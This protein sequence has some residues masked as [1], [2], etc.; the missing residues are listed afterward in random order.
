MTKQVKKKMQDFLPRGK[1]P[2]VDAGWR[3][4]KYEKWYSRFHGDLIIGRMRARGRGGSSAAFLAFLFAL[5]RLLHDNRSL[6]RKIYG[7]P[8]LGSGFGKP[9]MAGAMRRSYFGPQVP[10]MKD[11]EYAL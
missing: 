2:G 1:F 5:T 6:L 3:L 4:V 11:L 8:E 9:P 10:Y 7:R